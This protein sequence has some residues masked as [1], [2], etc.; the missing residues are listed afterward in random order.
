MAG[1]TRRPVAG[2]EDVQ[3]EIDRLQAELAADAAEVPARQN[4]LA[5]PASQW[6]TVPN[7]AP[8]AY[9]HRDVG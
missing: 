3:R 9:T 5:L 1:A 6:E 4:A 7:A 2:E 8:A